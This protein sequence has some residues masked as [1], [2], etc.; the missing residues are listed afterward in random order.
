MLKMPISINW[1]FLC[2]FCVVCMYSFPILFQ[3]IYIKPT[4][5]DTFGSV[6]SMTRY[7]GTKIVQQANNFSCRREWLNPSVS[8]LLV[9][10]L[11]TWQV[12]ALPLLA[13]GGRRA[14]SIDCNNV[15]FILVILTSTFPRTSRYRYIITCSSLF[16][17]SVCLNLSSPLL[18]S[19]WVLSRIN[20][21]SQLDVFGPS[22]RFSTLFQTLSSP[23]P[24]SQRDVL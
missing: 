19:Q 20:K 8:S 3:S 18:L 5:S 12:K 17:V 1:F 15:Y 4:F 6:L 16:V 13:S 7:H 11:S 14:N 10:H 22:P 9:F 2:I 23:P 24:F 21:H